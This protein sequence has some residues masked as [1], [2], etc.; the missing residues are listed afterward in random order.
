M[1][2]SIVATWGAELIAL[3]A[4]RSWDALPQAWQLHDI[5]LSAGEAV[6]CGPPS[7]ERL[8]PAPSQ[9]V[10][11]PQRKQCE[12]RRTAADIVAILPIEGGGETLSEGRRRVA[13]AACRRAT[14]ALAAPAHYSAIR[15]EAVAVTEQP[16]AQAHHRDDTETGERA[17]RAKAGYAGDGLS[18]VAQSGQEPRKTISCSE[19][20]SGTRSLRLEIACSSAA[21]ANGTTAPH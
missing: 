10:P 4:T 1:F 16:A 20:S 15:P 18:P 11:D 12:Q 6:N 7:C 5:H 14:V 17:T 13:L 9:P 19:T 21:S 2:V 8:P 3:S